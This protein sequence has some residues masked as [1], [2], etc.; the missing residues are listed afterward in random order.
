MLQRL[1]SNTLKLEHHEIIVADNGQQTLEKARTEN[2]I[3]SYW[4]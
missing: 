1:I 4:M 2:L 3:S